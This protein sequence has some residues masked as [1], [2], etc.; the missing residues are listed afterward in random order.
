MSERDQHQKLHDLLQSFLDRNPHP[1][2]IEA[3]E[4]FLNARQTFSTPQKS[5][6]EAT[7]ER[8]YEYALKIQAQVRKTPSS[9]IKVGKDE[10]RE[11]KFE[12]FRLN[13]AQVST[14]L[15]VPMSALEEGGWLDCKL[16]SVEPYHNLQLVVN[17]VKHFLTNTQAE[18]DPAS[19]ASAAR[20]ERIKCLRRDGFGCIFQHTEISLVTSILPSSWN[21]DLEA[22]DA[23][24]AVTEAFYAFFGDV[25]AA[26]LC[27]PLANHTE[28]GSSDKYW[29]MLIMSRDLRHCWGQA[30]FGLYCKDITPCEEHDESTDL[31]KVPFNVTIQF[32]W[33]RRRW[34]MPND[35]ITLEGDDNEFMNM[36]ETQIKYER[37][38]S[39]RYKNNY[40]VLIEAVRVDTNTPILSGHEFTI[41]MPG[42]DAKKCKLMLDLQ[43][44]II[45]IA[46]MSG[47]A[48]YPDLLPDH[49]DWIK[50]KLFRE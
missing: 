25:L 7:R 2:A 10:N 43:W 20:G 33:L 36:V 1:T 41:T 42:E 37:D 46:A 16:P 5:D 48:G 23:T 24:F 12:P 40:G 35:K 32:N 22:V 38:G 6:L 9:Q 34:E 11:D 21:D 45:R 31:T 26:E 27:S 18:R 47:A 49:H 39:P 50:A 44:A 8:R 19:V 13:A 30:G 4:R 3:L 15:L 28:L 14:I 29:N 17:L